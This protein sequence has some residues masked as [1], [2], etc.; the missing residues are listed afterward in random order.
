MFR[1]RVVAK[2]RDELGQIQWIELQQFMLHQQKQRRL[3]TRAALNC[4]YTGV[5]V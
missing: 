2:D 5:W 4:E 1:E 3:H